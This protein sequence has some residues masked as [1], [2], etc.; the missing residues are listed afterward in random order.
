VLHC[1]LYHCTKF[2]VQIYYMLRDKKRENPKIQKS[3]NY[4]RIFTFSYIL[5]YNEFEF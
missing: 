3:E 2:K 4:L 5:M 1:L